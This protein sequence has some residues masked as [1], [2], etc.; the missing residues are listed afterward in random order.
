[1][2]ISSRAQEITRTVKEELLQLDRI[3][4]VS[5]PGPGAKR[6]RLGRRWTGRIHLSDRS[7]SMETLYHIN[8]TAEPKCA[9]LRQSTVP[10]TDDRIIFGSF[11]VGCGRR[12]SR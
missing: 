7:V 9:A 12:A 3:S 5:S 10:G 1:M 8:L 6:W 4:S 2:Y 11:T